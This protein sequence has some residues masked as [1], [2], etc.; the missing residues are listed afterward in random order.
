MNDPQGLSLAALPAIALGLYIGALAWRPLLYAGLIAQAAYIASRGLV[1]GR[2]PLIGVHDTLNF[3]AA[4]VAA[5]GLAVHHSG[6]QRPAYFRVLALICALCTAV[7]LATPPHAGFLPPILRTYWFELHVALSFFSYAVFAVATVLGAIYLIERDD[8]IERMQY[9]TIFTGYGLFSLSMIAGGI[10]AYF[11]W[12]TYWLWTPKEVWTT[13]LWIY[14]GFYLHARLVRGWQG[15]KV[16]IVGT[17]G[18]GVVL[19]T[20]LGVSL[21]M[22]SSHS[23]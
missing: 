19:F 14:Y 12:G 10:W 1:M 18:F 20:Y 7:A 16:S 15:R 4:S 2:L 22:K 5:F 8:A 23:F 13:V 9:R 3:L 11:A 6:P 17:A 21:L